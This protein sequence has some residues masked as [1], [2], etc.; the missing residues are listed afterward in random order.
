MSCLG[1]KNSSL[2]ALHQLPHRL[3]CVIS[4]R[5]VQTPTLL[6]LTPVS[7]AFR[8]LSQAIL[9]IMPQFF[10]SFL[11]IHPLITRL[12]T[13]HDMGVRFPT[14]ATISSPKGHTGSVASRMGTGVLSLGVKR[15]GS[16]SEYSP[17]S[18]AE[19]KNEWS[20]TSTPPICLYVVDRDSFIFMTLTCR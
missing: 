9:E 6:L 5:T 11:Q 15:P 7:Q 19:V 20:N 18:S 2:L 1:H 8:Q 16:E 14:R 4:R 12:Y 13:Y 3:Q 17:S 10:T